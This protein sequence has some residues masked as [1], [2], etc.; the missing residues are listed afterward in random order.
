M[1]TS[2]RFNTFRE[3]PTLSRPGVCPAAPRMLGPGCSCPTL[4]DT[5]QGRGLARAF[6]GVF[7]GHYCGRTAVYVRGTLHS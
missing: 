1:S 2:A 3:G 7:E 4:G 5:Q 6:L